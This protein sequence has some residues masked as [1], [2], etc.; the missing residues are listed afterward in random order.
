VLAAGLG[1]ELGEDG[2]RLAFSFDAAPLRLG[3]GLDNG[4]GLLRLGRSFELG[5]LLGLASFG[6]GERGLG[7]GPVLRFQ[8]GGFGLAFA[9]FAE[10]I[11]LGFLDQQLRLRGGHHGLGLVFTLDGLGV[12][13]GQ[14]NAH[15]L[16]GAFDLSVA[17]EA[18]GLFADLLL[19]LQL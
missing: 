14:S 4:A 11:S 17:L 12:G 2:R 8:H 1:V 10:L 9:L 5:P 16:L 13:V 15:L 18:G 6:L 3:F 7:H 19:F